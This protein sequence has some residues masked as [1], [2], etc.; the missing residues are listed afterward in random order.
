MGSKDRKQ[1]E[2]EELRKRILQAASDIIA[3]KGYGKLTIRGLAARI[4][5]SP[6]AIYLYFTNKDDLLQE[7]IEYGFSY[8]VQQMSH[9]RD[10]SGILP[11]QL[12][13]Q[14]IRNH[15]QMAFDHPNFYRA[16]I[17]LVQDKG[18]DPG[19]NQ[20]KV[21]NF[22]RKN[23]ERLEPDSGE[24]MSAATFAFMSALRGLT[25]ALLNKREFLSV[26]DRENTISAFISML[27]KG[28][29]GG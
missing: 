5:Y 8:T 18:Y 13:M 11:E 14:S 12:I 7:V 28:I 24:D 3:E 15:I 9:Q 17:H 10:L 16:V 21:L 1:R 19:P 6:R 25:I 23:F 4:E 27:L 22:A 26:E 20:T 29:R 2:K